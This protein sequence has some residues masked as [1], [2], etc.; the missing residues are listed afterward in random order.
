MQKTFSES[1]YR[2]ADLNITLRPTIEVKRQLFRGEEWYLIQ[3]P[4]NNHFFRIRPEAYN[5]ISRLKKE[6]TVEQVWEECLGL[7]PETAPGQEEVLQLLSQLYYADI[8]YYNSTPDK[9]KLFERYKKRK[10]KENRSKLM[11]IMFIR[12][13]LLDPDLFLNRIM[14]VIKKIF[15]IP[16]FLV[17]CLILFFAGKTLV[18]NFDQAL[19]QAQG[20]LAQDNLIWLY[21]GLVIVKVLHEFGHAVICKKFR[22]EVHVMGVML[23]VFSPLPYMDA[24]SSW[25]F[26]EPWKRMAVG[27]AGM[28]VELFIAGLAVFVWA[29][30]GQGVLHSVA[31]NIMFIASVSTVL[32]NAN[33][34]IRFD[35]YYILSDFLD[36]PNLS[37]KAIHQLQHLVEKYGFGLKDSVSPAASKTEAV[38]LVVYGILSSIYRVIVFG[39]IILFI[40]DKFL[41]AGLI[42]A[43]ICLVS[44]VFIPLT[45][46]LIY[47]SS[48]PKLGR[49]RL[50][51]VTI[52][53]ACLMF[54]FLLSA[55]IPMPN[56]FRSPGIIEA[57][58][59]TKVV[60]PV[61]GYVAETY[62]SS[63]ETVKKG[64]PLIRMKN[65]E[66]FWEM[67]RL[68]AQLT[69]TLAMEKHAM[70]KTL[71]D[72][73]P[74][75]KRLK[76]IQ[77]AI[78][79]L[80]SQIDGLAIKARKSGTWVSPHADEMI[81]T[82]SPRG[83]V[84]GEIIN[85]ETFRFSAVI[86]QDEASNLFENNIQKAE[87]RL[88]GQ[89]DTNIK[90]SGYRIIP[91][92]HER[93]PS[94]ALGWLGGGD[95]AVSLSDNGGLQ[96]KEPF[97]LVHADLQKT[98]SANFLHGR[99][100]KIRFTLPPAPLLFQW[101]RKIRQ[102]L[103]KRYR[104]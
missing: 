85:P 5:F 41:L 30:T 75:K 52:T 74:I 57:N 55:V 67:E 59:Y 27:A 61:A 2:I 87:V 14:P 6:R 33:P 16:G 47:L 12:I 94:A 19:E 98:S 43:I 13:P 104:I 82:W 90:V 91:Y 51:A 99:S 54:F 70:E 3:D 65:Q 25:G 72:L 7:Y 10:Q 93:L 45:R 53:T 34:L 9:K 46:F 4:F 68:N 42:M 88:L 76:T 89:A 103:Q 22:G 69:E 62:I 36:I 83:G 84:I 77:N 73:K 49:N 101:E 44:W 11:S 1:W 86:S 63:G 100:G 31:Y 80:K 66:L 26:R 18:D 24:T 37:G 95:V 48:S 60:V 81:G 15:S 40:A 92:R 58:T 38:W 50:R 32:F 97:F 78:I 96:T 71:S 8:L 29:A 21:T 56:R 23:M 79:N 39:G 102:L 64:V 28:F 35:G 20:V 17:W